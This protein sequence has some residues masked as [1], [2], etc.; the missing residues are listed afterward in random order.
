MK[1]V[2]AGHAEKRASVIVA[3]LEHYHQAGLRGF[4]AESVRKFTSTTRFYTC[5]Q[6]ELSCRI[7]RHI[8]RNEIAM[9]TTM[10]V[11]S[12]TKIVIS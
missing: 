3:S 8:E 5:A 12:S 2:S 1:R 11:L 10:I 4:G 7:G 9:L 6:L